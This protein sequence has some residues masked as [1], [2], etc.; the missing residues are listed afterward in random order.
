MRTNK[1]YT[2][3][4]SAPN[5]SSVP[6]NFHTKLESLAHPKFGKV[7]VLKNGQLSETNFIKAL[8]LKLFYKVTKKADLTNR[9]IVEYKGLKFLEQNSKELNISDQN[10]KPLLNI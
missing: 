10:L 8:F 5:S 2:F 6:E 1:L 9:E 4:S 3:S 7:L